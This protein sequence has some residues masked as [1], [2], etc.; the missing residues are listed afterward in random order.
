[1]NVTVWECVRFP[2][3]AAYRK[4]GGILS[5]GTGRLVTAPNPLAPTGPKAAHKEAALRSITIILMTS[6]NWTSNVVRQA[7]NP[8]THL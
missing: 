8:P 3:W 6:H 5:D 1:M 7:R 2:V 4:R